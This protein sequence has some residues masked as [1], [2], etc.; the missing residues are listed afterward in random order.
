MLCYF[1]LLHLTAAR[2]PKSSWPHN[3]YM[4]PVVFHSLLYALLS[5]TK[6]RLLPFAMNRKT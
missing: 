5:V 1:Y 2:N 6:L 3:E 4:S